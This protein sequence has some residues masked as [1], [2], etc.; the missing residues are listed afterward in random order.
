[1][2]FLQKNKKQKRGKENLVKENVQALPADAPIPET[3]AQAEAPKPEEEREPIPWSEVE[4]PLLPHTQLN[5]TWRDG[6]M[7]PARI[8][9]R[10]PLKGGGADDWEY[11]IHYR[12]V[13]RR[14][15]CWKLLENFD[16]DSIIPP[17]LLDAVDPKYVMHSSFIVVEIYIVVCERLECVCFCFSAGLKSQNMRKFIAK[18]M[19]TMDSL[20]KRLELM[21]KPQR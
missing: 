13:D 5:C 20:S 14:M 7:R 21:K 11:Y 4:L 2:P 18:M 19:D 17:R 1:M 3:Q 16:K 8:I 12:G 10:R 9:E 15:D 6:T